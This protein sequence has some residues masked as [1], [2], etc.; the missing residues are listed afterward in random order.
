MNRFSKDE[1]KS[2]QGIEALIEDLLDL[3]HTEE[4]IKKILEA[5]NKR[6]DEAM[7]NLEIKKIREN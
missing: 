1:E 4:E 5:C 6:W 2:L 3:G 7:K